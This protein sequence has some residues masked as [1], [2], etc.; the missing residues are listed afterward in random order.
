MKV[1][2]AFTLI[3]LLIVIAIIGI[4]ASLVLVSLSRAKAK[5]QRTSTLQTINNVSTYVKGCLLGG[6][7][8]SN[9]GSAP[10]PGTSICGGAELWP[11]LPGPWIYGVVWYDTSNAYFWIRVQNSPTSATDVVI[12]TESPAGWSENWFGTLVSGGDGTIKCVA[13]P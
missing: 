2:K 8:L 11:V 5:A 3:E 10:T 4:L 6:L 9:H 1:K 12:C 7:T 13:L